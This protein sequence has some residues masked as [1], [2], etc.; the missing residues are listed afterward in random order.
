[1][2]WSA[3]LP[4]AVAASISVP[5][6]I[7]LGHATEGRLKATL[8]MDGAAQG[9]APFREAQATLGIDG[10]ASTDD[11]GGVSAGGG[12]TS[13]TVTLAERPSRSAYVYAMPVSCRL[14]AIVG[15]ANTGTARV[16]LRLKDGSTRKLPLRRTP[17]GWHYAGHMIGGFVHTSSRIIGVRAYDARGHVL[18]GAQWQPDPTCP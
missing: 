16:V 3:L 5:G 1:M 12:I 6:S 11:D 2:I 18:K 8:L 17:K 14:Q 15:S 13:A 9:R 10:P 7:P 4:I